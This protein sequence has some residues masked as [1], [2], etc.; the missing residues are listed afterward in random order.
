MKRSY[1]IFALITALAF[2]GCDDSVTP[3]PPLPDPETPPELILAEPENPGPVPVTALA[4]S[5]PDGE[6]GRLEVDDGEQIQLNLTVTPS[7]ASNQN[8][9]WISSDPRIAAVDAGGLVTAV[10]GGTAT[11]KVYSKADFSVRAESPDITAVT[12]LQGV[13]LNITGLKLL[14]KGQN[15]AAVSVSPA[16][17]TL[18]DLTFTWSSSAESAVTVTASGDG[19][20]ALIKGEA[21]GTATVTVSVTDTV[22]NITKQADIAVTVAAPPA[23]FDFGASASHTLKVRS[24]TADPNEETTQDTDTFLTWTG[25]TWTGNKTVSNGYNG[26][27]GGRSGTFNPTLVYMNIPVKGEN[28]Y[29]WKARV[30]LQ[31]NSEGSNNNGMVIGVYADPENTPAG[32]PFYGVGMAHLSS[33]VLRTAYTRDSGGGF[34]SDNP[35]GGFGPVTRAPDEY[36]WAFSWDAAEQTYRMTLTDAEGTE[37]A[38]TF[39]NVYSGL[40]DP[41]AYYYPVIVVSN[42]TVTIK[43]LR[44][45]SP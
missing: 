8:V 17:V 43:E 37:T 20:S 41:D 29:T 2:F 32:A 23:A 19:K 21:A 7:N 6:D 44:I 22:K 18:S 5:L 16:T 1:C 14:P 39:S 33:N 42:A 36:T 12:H 45:T 31:A 38:Y 3:R 34:R 26:Q 4:I 30:S 25:S 15:T 11:I 9:W 27:V 13:S 28:S 35:G 10:S 24:L 40:L